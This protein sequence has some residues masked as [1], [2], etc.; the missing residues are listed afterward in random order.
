MSRGS[1]PWEAQS[2]VFYEVWR[3][4]EV[5]ILTWLRV[6]VGPRKE[7]KTPETLEASEFEVWAESD[8]CLEDR[9][10]GRLHL[11]YSTCLGGSWELRFLR[12]STVILYRVGPL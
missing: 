9:G 3:L 6:G 8:E 4:Q 2:L 12:S 10:P 1:C 11:S 7:P 5:Q